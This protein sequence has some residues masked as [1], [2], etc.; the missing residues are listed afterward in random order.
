MHITFNNT[1]S[2]NVDKV[3]T[4][5]HT[6]SSAPKRAESGYAL[7]ISG[8]VT[9][10]TAYGFH[11]SHGVHGRT[12]E[13]VVQAAGSED[14]TLY[15]NYM[16]VMSHSMSD[17]DFAKLQKE[18]RSLTDVDI[19]EAVTILD[20]IKA[21]MIKGGANVVGYTDDID[22]DKLAEITGSMAFAEQL[23][24]AF[25]MEDIPVTQENVEQALEAF[26]RGEELTELSDGAMKYMVTNEMEPDID[27]LYLA[28]HA[29]AVD[30]SRQGQGYFAEEMP[31]YYAQKASAADTEKLRAQVEKIIENAGYPV[32]EETLADGY[33]LIEK[34]VPF[35]EKSFRL[36][37]ELKE[38]QLP[39]QTEDLLGAIAGALS[40]GR[41][42][43]EANLAEGRSVYRRAVECYAAYENK[44]Q[45]SLEAEPTAENVKARRQL[46]EVRLHM[47]LEANVKLLK[48]GF[49]IDTAPMEEL[50]DALKSLEQK[51][52]SADFA[53]SRPADLCEEAVSK[54]KE[55]PYLPAVT[56]GRLISLGETISVD[57]VYETGKALEEVFRQAG[58][59][60]ETMMTV[61][62]A[63]LGDNIQSAFRNVDALLQ[64]MGQEL[65]EENRKAVRSLSYNRQELTEENLLAVKEA[66]KV[67]QRVVEK[68]TP[69]AVLGMIRDGVN[70]L[71]SSMEELDAYFSERDTYDEE[72]TKY[73]SFLYHLE[74]RNE[75]TAE[76]KESY[77]GIYRLLRQIEKSDGAAVG[78]L[79]SSQ[80]EVNF[81]N[82][83]SAIRTG[84]VKGVD[85]SV[86]SG[87][88]GLREAVEQGA[89]ID[90]QIETA[91]NSEILTQI[92]SVDKIGD[93]VLQDLKQLE[94][95]ITIDNLLAADALRKD[96]AGPFKKLREVVENSSTSADAAQ[97]FGEDI[98]GASVDEAAF[99]DR[100][101][102]Q[103]TYSELLRQG[104][105]MAKELTFTES[106]DSLDVRAMQLVC[107]QLHI[108][109]LRA[110]KEEEYD[111]PQVIDGEL[112]A[113]HLKL[114]HNSEESG[115]I[116]IGVDTAA[117]GYLSG[118]FSVNDRTVSGYLGG[119][120]GE[121]AALLEKAAEHFGARL[122]AAGFEDSR[123]QVVESSIS[124]SSPAESSQK[125]ETKELYRIAGMALGALKEALSEA[126]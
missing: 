59:A 103:R 52:T 57:S 35:T 34:G 48:S 123:I 102:L 6:A 120:G 74:S 96:G 90:V 67:V 61:P 107:K 121:A 10:N 105:A 93:E 83:L 118:E 2:S 3:T 27:N 58:E 49:S 18:G 53:V 91:F 20:T 44:Y 26:S 63:D 11:K 1:P 9:E 69:A 84:R 51:Q 89:S 106:A 45:A 113:I 12:A 47:T 75:I 104:E 60:Y 28:E 70:P 7:D 116:S 99:S 108:Q 110:V 16:T 111:L 31:G 32:T 24:Q 14:L 33:W 97:S 115:K 42:A 81:E 13:E 4:S 68:M 38:V 94:Q 43:G 54:A 87:F 65:T 100:E 22:M 21:E 86:D 117:F 66:D 78:K 98:S 55:I 122:S 41:P 114:V 17:E 40:E 79:V 50:I 19:E 46:E 8:T 126:I 25:A 37:E 39:A 36:M 56:L 109:G 29:G 64:D 73:S 15:R 101:S 80:A 85:I 124:S 30:A 77:I 119:S 5:Y 71:K 88:G 76:E 23:V 92:R 112:T 82:L 95:P 72:S 125:E 62:R